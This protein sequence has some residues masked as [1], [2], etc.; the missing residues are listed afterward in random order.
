MTTDPPPTASHDGGFFGKLFDFSFEQ[1]ITLSIIKV[2]YILLIVLSGLG[3]LGLLISLAAQGGAAI[4]LG[5]ILAP[6]VFIVYVILARVWLEFLIVVF[7]I[8]DNTAETAR[9]TR[10]R[11]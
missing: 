8:A 3:A 7:R 2:I 11:I 6:I 10:D 1:F 5:L 9:N 4:V